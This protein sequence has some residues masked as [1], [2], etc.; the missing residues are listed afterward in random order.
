MS[1][2]NDITVDAFNYTGEYINAT[3][4]TVVEAIEAEKEYNILLWG[5]FVLI[6]ACILG[7]RLIKYLYKLHQS[8]KYGYD[9]DLLDDPLRQLGLAQLGLSINRGYDDLNDIRKIRKEQRKLENRINRKDRKSDQPPESKHEKKIPEATGVSAFIARPL[10][11]AENYLAAFHL[12]TQKTWMDHFS[13]EA[14]RRWFD[15]STFGRFW[16]MFQVLCTFVSIINYVFLTYAIQNEERTFIKFLD[17]ALA[18][19]FLADYSISLYI[20]DDRLA[21][22]FNY[23]SMID[24]I[25]IVPPFIYLIVR[26]HSQFIW[27]LGLLRILRASRILRTYRLLSFQ[28]TEETRELTIVALT[29]CNFIFLSASIINALETINMNKQS[30]PSLTYWHD[31]LY[32]IMVTFSTIGF[33]DLTPSSTASRVVVMILIVFVIIYVPVQTT[34]MTEIYYSSSPYQRAKYTPSKSLA[35]VILSGSVSYTGIVDFCK[36]FF[37]ADDSSNV[38]ILSQSLPGLPIRKLLR[39]PMYRN[40]VHYLCGSALSAGDLKRAGAKYATALFL[41]NEPID[42]ATGAP[43][44]ED[45]Q[46]RVTRGADAEI[47]MQALVAKKIYPGIPIIGE[48]LDIRSQDLST[49]CGC[50]RVLCSDKFKMAILARECLVPGFLTLALNIISTYSNEQSPFHETEPWMYEYT[51]GASNQIFSF[52]IPPGLSMLKWEEVVESV[53][54]TFNVTIFAVVSLGGPQIGKLR[55]NPGREYVTRGDDVLFC[56]TNGGDEVVLRLSIQF[57][58]Q[59]P[60]E[61]LEMLELDAELSDKLTPITAVIPGS[62]ESLEGERAPLNEAVKPVGLGSSESIAEL[63]GHIILCGNVSARGIRHFVHSIRKAEADY[64]ATL[65]VGSAHHTIKIVCLMEATTDA[66]TGSGNEGDTGIWAD[67]L[68]DGNVKIVKGTPLKKTSLV[69]CGIAKC[70]RIVIFSTPIAAPTKSDNANILPDA[71]SIFIIKMIQEEWPAVNFT[72]ELVSGLNV[73]Y[74]GA[75]QRAIEW[76]TDNLRM[77]SIL[78][79]YTLSIH[80]RIS[81]YKK[82]RQRGADHEG[83][84]WQLYRFIWPAA[85]DKN[86]SSSRQYLPV[87]RSTTPIPKSNA[88]SD[89]TSDN[90]PMLVDSTEPSPEEGPTGKASSSVSGAYLQKLVEE[91]ELNESGFHPFLS[92]HFD[93][94]F[95]Q[96]RVI[97]VSFLHSLL[98]QS[99]FRPYVGDIV[100]ALASCVTQI[101]VPAKYHGRKYSDLLTYLLKRDMIPLGLYR[102]SNR[103]EGKSGKGKGTGYG[104][105]G[106]GRSKYVYT[107][108]RGFDVVDQEDLV[109]AFYVGYADDSESIDSIMRK[110]NE[111]EALKVEVAQAKTRQPVSDQ[112]ASSSLVSEDPAASADGGDVELGQRELEELF[113]RTSKGVNVKQLVSNPHVMQQIIMDEE[114]SWSGG[115]AEEDDYYWEEGDSDND[116]LAALELPGELGLSDTK[117]APRKRKRRENAT[118]TADNNSSIGAKVS[119][120]ARNKAGIIQAFQSGSSKAQLPCARPDPTKPIHI[121]IPKPLARAW[122]RPIE[123]L[124]APEGQ[125]PVATKFKSLRASILDPS[126]LETVA[127][128]CKNA[129][130]VYMDPPLCLDSDRVDGKREDGRITT[131]ELAKLDIPSLIKAGF[132][133][134]WAEKEFTPKIL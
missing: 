23:S 73:R 120:Q 55:L 71:S 37:A 111:L 106:E 103:G 54:K 62:V 21:F 127:Q 52:K 51:L 5:P 132:L 109:S 74:F 25:S 19:V 123:L 125:E 9:E 113:R 53:F 133:F 89:D 47:L 116:E 63:Q 17:V 83:F 39:H 35:H 82:I 8:I 76:D 65:A 69:I 114:G 56:L 99:Y 85:V 79:N 20:A 131:S 126:V 57:K 87:P 102:L 50:D 122:G 36:E 29:F 59:M 66:T 119:K 24:L 46:I 41:I 94:N 93:K 78:N 96:G 91:A 26:D 72:V 101:R 11:L 61:Q 1:A 134:I 115:E 27:F 81:L 128:T 32:Y 30:S 2:G 22:Y 121:R 70:R 28:E 110:F 107:N 68:N 6:P 18:A 42:T 75:K 108:C 44:H 12:Q 49:H 124:S 92:H 67:I 34:R 33:G 10:F 31:S 118:A 38:V 13:P 105:E 86:M 43:S 64:Q 7:A 100:S 77:Q 48:V 98:A 40:R 117:P 95:A 130:V 90:K 60:R 45:E 4:D 97:P 112:G 104:M 88:P 129:I 15:S 84:L 14:I 16:M 3:F 80:D 58:D